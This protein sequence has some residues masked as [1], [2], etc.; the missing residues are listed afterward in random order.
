MNILYNTIPVIAKDLNLKEWDIMLLLDILENKPLHEMEWKALYSSI[1]ELINLGYII[2]SSE[3]KVI[4]NMKKLRELFSKYEIKIKSKDNITDAVKDVDNWIEQYRNLFVGKCKAAL[5][6]GD[7]TICTM[8][9]KDFHTRFP[10]YSKDVILKATQLGIQTITQKYGD[11]F[12]PQADNFI[13]T[14]TYKTPGG[15]PVKNKVYEFAGSKL[16]S[17]CEIVSDMIQ[18]GKEVKTSNINPKYIKSI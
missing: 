11:N 9:M 13:L 14:D 16:A 8:R 10:E 7:K 5:P 18:E 12:V 3:E 6:K 15:F 4:G 17:Y 1:Q 2:S